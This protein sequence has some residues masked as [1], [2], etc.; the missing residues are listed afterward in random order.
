MPDQLHC[1]LECDCR[2]RLQAR[3]AVACIQKGGS[4]WCTQQ[5]QDLMGSWL[6][7]VH[8]RH[9]TPCCCTPEQDAACCVC[10][11]QPQQG[12]RALPRRHQRSKRRRKRQPAE[13]GGG[14]KVTRIPPLC[15]IQRCPQVVRAKQSHEHAAHANPPLGH[16]A[17]GGGG[18]AAKASCLRNRLAEAW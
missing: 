9:G 16:A 7:R 13:D 11:S 10:C 3:Q 14:I 5:R 15:I 1:M 17:A 8:S 4:A 2:N 12:G 18:A 6:L